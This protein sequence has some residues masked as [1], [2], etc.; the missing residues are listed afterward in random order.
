[1]NK[2]TDCLRV[3]QILEECGPRGIHSFDLKRI[4]F[5]KDRYIARVGD[6]EKS[7]YNLHI[8]HIPE[9]K[10]EHKGTR[11]ILVNTSS[12]KVSTVIKTINEQTKHIFH[13]EFYEVKRTK[14]GIPKGQ[15]SFI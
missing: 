5:G 1:M 11:Y 3:K 8:L 7:P 2:Q 4:D 13:Q 15:L 9:K 6:L 10:G 12:S 14:N